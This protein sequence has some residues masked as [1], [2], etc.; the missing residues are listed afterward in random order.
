MSK[1]G[2]NAQTFQNKVNGAKDAH[3]F[4]QHFCHNSS[5]N[6]KLRFC[7][8]HN[9]LTN[10][11]Q[12]LLPFKAS[13]LSAQKLL[14]IGTKDVGKID[15]LCLYYQTFYNVFCHSVFATISH[16]HSSLLFMSKAGSQPYDFSPLRGST[17]VNSSLVCT[18]YTSLEMTNNSKHYSLL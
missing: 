2:Q 15:S 5:A 7:P 3:L 17:M 18:C 13:K 9:I 8:K 1:D 16:F 4:H 12:L 11:C 10:F 14:C 6:S